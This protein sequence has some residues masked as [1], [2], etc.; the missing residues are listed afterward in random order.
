MKNTIYLYSGPGA[1]P[2]CLYQTMHTLLQCLGSKYKISTIKQE[3]VKTGSWQKDA[4][5]FVMP[6]GGDVWYQMYLH[7]ELNQ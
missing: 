5:C 2:G 3:D 7:P 6:G 1:A 4:A